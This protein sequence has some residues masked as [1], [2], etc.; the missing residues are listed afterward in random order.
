MT[1]LNRI[2]DHGSTRLT[3]R[4]ALRVD[5]AALTVVAGPFGAIMDTPLC[6]A[7]AIAGDVLAAE[8][9]SPPE[10]P[11]EAD[12]PAVPEPRGVLDL[13]GSPW[14]SVPVFPVD[15]LF[16]GLADVA[17]VPAEEPGD[18][19]LPE[20]PHA[21]E[22]ENTDDL[23]DAGVFDFADVSP[24][25]LADPADD[26]PLPA[27]PVPVP[28][29]FDALEEVEPDDG[30]DEAADVV[31]ARLADAEDVEGT[32]EP[33]EDDEEDEEDEAADVLD[34]LPADVDLSAPLVDLSAGFLSAGFVDV[35][36]A[37]PG[38]FAPL[39]PPAALVDVV[40]DLLDA[41]DPL[42]VE[43]PDAVGDSGP[44]AAVDA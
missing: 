18:F 39:P 37:G 42:G 12:A 44:S 11:A 30:A 4:W 17:D 14:G 36:A 9:L 3:A 1:K 33:V 25:S 13:L 21:P 28:A 26:G 20:E 24:D 10:S 43:P 19:D 2:T 40:L 23:P 35:S 16:E 41:P 32:E 34:A 29:D 15:P 31:E 8:P 27:D 6:S 5:L 7:F 38:F 22:P